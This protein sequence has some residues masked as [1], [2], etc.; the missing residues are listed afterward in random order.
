MFS[1][2]SLYFLVTIFGGDKIDMGLVVI[3]TIVVR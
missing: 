1:T 2:S 3:V